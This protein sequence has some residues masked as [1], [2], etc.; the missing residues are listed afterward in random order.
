MAAL[1]SGQNLFPQPRGERR[2]RGF[3]YPLV[4]TTLILFLL[5]LQFVPNLAYQLNTAIA[6]TLGVQPMNFAGAA[7]APGTPGSPG[8][9]GNSGSPGLD[10]LT[11]SAGS[12]GPAGPAGPCAPSSPSAPAGP[13]GPCGPAGPAGRFASW[14]S[15][16]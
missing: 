2:R 11:G 16:S 10:G 5:S 3:V 14:S 9:A 1:I 15:S 13:A 4:S 8:I 6:N 12:A 7:G